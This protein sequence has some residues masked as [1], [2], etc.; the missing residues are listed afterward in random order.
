ML[1]LQNLSQETHLPI[2]ITDLIKNICVGFL[3]KVNFVCVC[4]CVCIILSKIKA[5]VFVLHVLRTEENVFHGLLDCYILKI[6][7]EV[8]IFG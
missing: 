4:V 1:T 5:A 3:L 2:P 7:F 6:Q 8:H